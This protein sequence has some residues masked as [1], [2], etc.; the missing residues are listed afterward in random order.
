MKH[1]FLLMGFLLA[2]LTGMAQQKQTIF[3]G[4]VEITNDTHVFQFGLHKGDL[5]IVDLETDKRKI[6]QFEVVTKKTR[7]VARRSR[8]EELEDYKFRIPESS[9]YDF[10]FTGRG[11]ARRNAKVTI[12]RQAGRDGPKVM[13]PA[14]FKETRYDTTEIVYECDTVI[15]TLPAVTEKVDLELFD[16]YVYQTKEFLN[17]SFQL[18]GSLANDYVRHFSYKVP[19]PQEG[20]NHKGFSYTVSSRI[21]GAKH[22]KLAKIGVSVGSMFVNPA[23]GFASSHLMDVMGPQPGGEPSLLLFSTEPDDAKVVREILNGQDVLASSAKGML[24]KAT[25]GRLGDDSPRSTGEFKGV[26]QMGMITAQ[27]GLHYNSLKECTLILGNYDPAKA[28]NV[29]LSLSAI[30]SAPLYRKVKSEQKVVNP[31]LKK[32]QKKD[33]AI[34]SEHVYELL[35]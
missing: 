16:R 10:K 5:V 21:G 22:W 33:I 18:K 14:F 8:I 27:Y 32:L 7:V 24:S 34:S 13:N 6:D 26:F 9:V 28:K 11:L 35:D 1:F 15:G 17:E 2:V 3:H 29:K 20:L 19:D 25:G 30:Q 31:E 4:Y 12:K 23:L